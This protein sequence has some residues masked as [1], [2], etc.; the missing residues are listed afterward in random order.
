M[1]CAIDPP[2]ALSVVVA[3]AVAPATRGELVVAAVAAAV[4]AMRVAVPLA[5][6]AGAC[7]APWLWAEGVFCGLF[8][9]REEVGTEERLVHVGAGNGYMEERM[10]EV[11]AGMGSY[12]KDVKVNYAYKPRVAMLSCCC[13]LCLLPLLLFICEVRSLFSGESCSAARADECSGR[14]YDA[15]TADAQFCCASC[16]AAAYSVS[17]CAPEEPK[18]HD[19]VRH[20]YGTV[21]RHIPVNHYEVKVQMP[22]HAPIIHTVKVVEPP[23]HYE[24]A[25]HAETPNPEWT[26]KHIRWCCYEHKMFC[27]VSVVDKNI[28]HHITKVQ[29][30]R[31]PVPVPMPAHHPIIHTVTHQYHVP[32]PPQYV[33]VHVP[34]PTVYHHVNVPVD[35]PYPVPQA[36]EVIN[37]KKEYPVPVPGHT[38]YVHVPVPSPPHV[39]THYHTVWNTVQDTTY[40]CHSGVDHWHSI[41]SHTKQSW[42]CGHYNV[43]CAGSWVKEVHVI[44]TT[45]YNCAA[46]YS[47][48]Y[49]GWSDA[50]KGWCCDHENR[51]CPGSWHGHWHAHAVVHVEHGV[52]VG[53]GG[54]DCAAGVS[55]WEQGW[56]AHKKDFCCKTSDHKFC[57]E[58]H[59]RG[60]GAG[61][62]HSWSK[63]KSDFCCGH[64][65]VGCPA[66]T[67]SPL[68]CEAQCTVNGETS[69]CNARIQWAQENSFSGKSNA[70]NLAYSQI[71][72]ECD[73]CRACSVQAAGCGVQGPG[74]EPFD[75]Q[76]AL[77]NWC[78]AWSPNKKV[79]CCNSKKL[80]CQ[81]M[82]APP[83]CDAGAGMVWKKVFIDGHWTWEASGAG[84]AVVVSKPYACHAGLPNW[85]TGWSAPKKSWCCA[86]ENLGCPG[87]VYHGPG[88]GGSTH[89]VVTHHYVA[90]GGAAGGGAAGGGAAGGG[91]AGGGAAGGGSW[92]SGGGGSW[93]SGGGGG[94]WH[95]HS[96]GGSWH[97]HTVVH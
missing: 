28:Y 42:C 56:S 36:P 4:A 8:Y 17:L 55:N 27:P 46:G 95:S 61:A 53:H 11:G 54:Y 43:G 65:Q 47:N 7:S 45:H 24:C 41:W 70:C 64:F 85:N 22:P 5:A 76:A 32:S 67:L 91:A 87:F 84:G 14:C 82:D 19:I 92:H 23:T 60:E 16:P 30:Y 57:V 44:H 49:H 35:V 83:N 71:Q 1:D 66:T 59:C 40:D 62:V 38:H 69:T 94:S 89:V 63:D 10:V 58:Y 3:S 93:H 21:Y 81:T 13:L 25:S 72:V 37:V 75:C 18:V 68:G 6:E 90:G 2:R 88:A 74:S 80:G 50:K 31:V 20:H 73:V 26:S 12:A 96:S 34:G 9:A 77:G 15:A 52:H 33:H 79:W 48:W 29:Q 39:V 86:H 51:G 97:S 78:R